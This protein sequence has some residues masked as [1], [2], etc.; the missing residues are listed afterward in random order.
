MGR[1]RE[2]FFFRT[3]HIPAITGL[4]GL[5][6]LVFFHMAFLLQFDP[7]KLSRLAEAHPGVLSAYNLLRFLLAPGM[8]C[9]EVLFVLAGFLLAMRLEQLTL[10][11]FVLD[12]TRRLY[13]VY[14][15]ILLPFLSYTGADWDMLGSSLSMLAVPEGGPKYT[16]VLGSLLWGSIM[17][18]S[19]HTLLGRVPY[20]AQLLAFVALL[21]W[22]PFFMPDA[23]RAWQVLGLAFG[24]GA[25]HW[26]DR[27]RAGPG[28]NAWSQLGRYPGLWLTL[29]LLL[30]WLTP[31]VP[32]PVLAPLREAAL[33]LALLG[34]SS[35]PDALCSPTH[36]ARLLSHPLLRYFGVTAYSFFLVQT[37][38]GV[39][40]SRSLLQGEMQS[41]ANILAHYALTLA[42]ST[43]FAGMLWV[44]F[45]RPGFLRKA[46]AAGTKRGSQTQGASS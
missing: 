12:R 34:L 36:T 13:P 3:D 11:A 8:A 19:L 24:L 15:L 46:P 41:A 21:A 1:L 5:A 28:H 16:W 26:R 29:F 14:I 4:R 30:A 17:W 33:A 35:P 45:E 43:L 44:F 27:L 7:A 42:F 6:M 20:W 18:M 9:A 22:G 38:W 39:R 31:F 23:A 40:L 25:W 2:L 10:P 37:T 32:L